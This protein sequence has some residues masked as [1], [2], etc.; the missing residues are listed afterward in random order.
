MK[1]PAA[2][3]Y[4]D[5]WRTSTT[6]MDAIT[7]A[8]YMDL[9]LHQY[10]K[11][12]LPNNIE[13]LA[14]ICRVRFSEFEQ[15]KQVF[16]Q[17]L[18]QKFKE[19]ENGRLENDFAS[20]IIRKRQSF[21]EKRSN[22]G[23]LSYVLKYFRKNY[24][25]NKGLENFIKDNIDL[26][27]DIKN[28]QVL[29]QVFEQISELYINGDEDENKDIDKEKTNFEIILDEWFDYK[30]KRGQSYKSEKSKQ[31]LATKLKELS[32][33]DDLKARKIIEQSMLN[34]WAGIFQLKTDKPT[35]A[36]TD[37]QQQNSNIDKW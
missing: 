18:K 9:L 25:I 31:L 36:I 3:L 4:I 13:E 14:N 8:Y 33:G 29:K 32:G 34:N 2:L 23:K 20:E 21:V 1:D 12:S 35:H 15:F 10:D 37:Y 22:A 24:K 28:E 30:K 19:N 27:F 7:R 17:V 26:D 5:S 11:G 16:E 6:E